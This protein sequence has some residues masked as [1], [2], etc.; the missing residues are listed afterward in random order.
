MNLTS[1]E[2]YSYGYRH[3]EISKYLDIMQY[4]FCNRYG[5]SDKHYNYCYKLKHLQD[6][7]SCDLDQIIHNSYPP[8]MKLLQK[9]DISL[10]SVFYRINRHRIDDLEDLYNPCKPYPKTLLPQHKVD[11]IKF[12]AIIKDYIDEIHN[13]FFNNHNITI[14]KFLKK[15]S[16]LDDFIINEAEYG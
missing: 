12:S 6:Q 8:N 11:L 1:D 5:V 9:Y 16:Q 13:V 10:G 3:G 7:I 2:W 14:K 15:L 4:I